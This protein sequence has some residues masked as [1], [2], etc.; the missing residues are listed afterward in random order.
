MSSLSG[1]YTVQ[2]GLLFEEGRDRD[3]VISVL[4]ALLDSGAVTYLLL[5][6]VET[7][8]VLT[9]PMVSGLYLAIYIVVVGTSAKWN[10]EKVY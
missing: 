3:R 2:T 8:T 6:Y 10:T 5:W 9:L 4:N 1:L 7:N